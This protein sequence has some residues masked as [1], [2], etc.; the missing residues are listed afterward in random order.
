MGRILRIVLVAVLALIVW[1][2]GVVAAALEGWGRR[3]LAPAGDA[4][5]F[6]TA[7]I[8]QADAARPGNLALVLLDDGRVLDTHFTSTGEPVDGDTLFQVASL[9]K[10]VTAWGVMRLVEAGKLDLDAPVSTYLTRWSLPASDFDNGKVTVRRLLSHTAGL[11]DGLG[12]GGFPPGRPVQTIEQ[13]LT[14]AADASPGHDGIVRVGAEPGSRFEY[15]GGGYTLLQLVIE[16]V[17]GRPFDAYMKQDVFRPLGMTRSTFDIDTAPPGNVA[18]SYDAH[19]RPA[20]LY[21]FTGL[22]A[23]SLYTSAADMT[24]FLQAHLPGPNGE[25]PGWGVLKPETLEAMRRPEARQMGADIWGLGTMLYAPNNAGGFII[26]HDGNNEP[27]IN[28]AARIDPN[29]GDGIVVLETG[30]PLLATRLGGE[31][32]FWRTG[33]VDFTTLLMEAGDL[34]KRLAAGWTVIVLAGAVAAWRW[35]RPRAKAVAP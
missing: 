21:R 14:R 10:W 11:T 28:T 2:A 25:P 12:Y 6:A 18:A 5:A 34:L 13:S 9:S 27:E 24:R 30:A 22:A 7:A 15:S 8:A 29:T 26:G 32:I 35:R 31:W 23:A 4:R 16:E 17:S 3:P 19:G 1:T 20:T 33:N